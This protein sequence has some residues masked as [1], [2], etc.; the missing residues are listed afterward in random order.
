MSLKNIAWR[1]VR[2]GRSASLFPARLAFILFPLILA[3]C[4]TSSD[5]DTSKAERHE[6]RAVALLASRTDADSL[7][8][9]ALLSSGRDAPQTLLLIAHATSV[10]PDR[11]D[12]VWLE[13]QVC[14]RVAS[15]DAQSVERRLRALDPSN[16]AGWMGELARADAAN[17]S[18]KRYSSLAEIS[19]SERV[20]VYWTTLIARLSRAA[21]QT[22]RMSLPE[23][24]TEVIGFLAAQGIPAF[25]V[26]LRVCKGDSLQQPEVLQVCRGAASA[27]S[28]GDTYITEMFGTAIAKRVWPADS[29]QWKSASEARRVYEY[30]SKLWQSL[31]VPA[32]DERTAGAYLAL[33]AY[34][35]REQDVLRAQLVAAGQNP[36]PPAP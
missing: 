24:E 16:G 22:G 15:C 14:A 23:A 6:K 34:N 20:D 10:A 2:P 31:E 11:P 8:A 30:R 28:A 36:D 35:R 33:C 1:T 21:A 29:P 19:R 13:A 9:A 26:A 12:L 18:E 3:S 32:L 27:F 7:A 5:A 4:V 17:D 25:G